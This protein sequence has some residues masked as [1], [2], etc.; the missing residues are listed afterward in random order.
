MTKDSVSARRAVAIRNRKAS[1]FQQ[2]AGERLR[3]PQDQSMEKRQLLI[4]DADARSRL[5]LRNILADLRHDLI[6]VE[7]TSEALSVITNQQIDLVLVDIN[8]PDMGGIEFC[9]MLRREEATRLVPVF[10]QASAEDQDCEVRAIEAGADEFL[11]SPLKPSA[12]RA[13]VQASIRH[14]V[15]LETMDESETVLF[16]LAKSVEDRDPDLGQHCQRLALMAAGMGIALGL[17][18]GDIL[19]L[20]RG[21]YLHDIGKIGIPDRI[22]F[23]A[24]MLTPDEWEIMKSHVTRGEKLCSCMKSL[25]PVLPIIRHHH[26]KWDGSGYPDGLKGERIPLLA[27][28]IQLADIYDALTTERPYKRAYTPEDALA[29]IR[30]ECD[31]GWR[32]RRLVELFSDLLPLFRSPGPADMSRLSL[33]SLSASLDQYRRDS[34]RLPD[35]NP[36][37]FSPVQFIR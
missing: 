17:P 30:E 23:K 36:S 20:Q 37:N 25:A 4:V 2:T 32:D 13:R 14:K 28:I 34:L 8:V 16:S 27:R 24:G 35:R 33:Q 29:V 18:P 3:D 10:V 19:S 15:M 9:E 6:E 22:L 21:G 5:Y 31:K 7:S 12:F 26:E 1:A 11:I